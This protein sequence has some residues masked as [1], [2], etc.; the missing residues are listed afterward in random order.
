MRFRLDG[1]GNSRFPGS[2]HDS[3]EPG[4]E[5]L[6]HEQ[7]VEFLK[8]V[9]EGLGWTLA[10]VQLGVTLRQMKRAMAASPAFRRAVEQV[11]QVR[12]ERMFTMLYDAA[13][14]GDTK[15]AQFLLARHDRQV[16]Q[17]KARRDASS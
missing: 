12:A 3:M 10:C 1:E 17:R 16:E 15:A 4:E 11:E 8:L 7:R 2:S 5:T 9:H 6:T 14:N 13:L